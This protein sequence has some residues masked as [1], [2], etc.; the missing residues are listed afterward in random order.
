MEIKKLSSEYIKDVA[1]I[2]SVYFSNPW[3]EVALF[4]ELSN[5]CS[6]F[7]VAVE[8]GK[9]VGYAGLY[10]VCGEADIVRVAVLPE[11]RRNGTA[12]ALLLESFKANSADCVFL[13]V[14]ESNTAAIELYKSLGFKDTGVRKNYYSNPTE[15]AVL[16]KRDS[17]MSKQYKPSAD[18]KNIKEI[19]FGDN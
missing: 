15:N 7:Y 10:V 19:S 9:A 12:K 18:H 4:G 11:Y 2:E 14:R 3:S 17:A 1:Y 6:H 8:N 13:D 16:M 5:D